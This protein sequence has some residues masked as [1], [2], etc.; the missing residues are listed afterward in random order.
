MNGTEEAVRWGL[1]AFSCERSKDCADRAKIIP[2]TPYRK[3]HREPTSTNEVYYS[4]SP[5]DLRRDIRIS[6][7]MS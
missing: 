5:G 6:A 4:F 2:P 3:T 7:Q 1:G